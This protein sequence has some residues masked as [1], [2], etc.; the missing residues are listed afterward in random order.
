ME[1]LIKKYADKMVAVGLC[2]PGAPL[3]GFLDAD[4][5]W[6]RDDPLREE[7]RKVFDRIS[8]NSLVCTQP[9]EPY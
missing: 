2:D 4:L 7:L 8:I 6:N 1:R 5:V 9:A 3:I